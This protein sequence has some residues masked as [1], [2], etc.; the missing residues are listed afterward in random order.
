MVGPE[1]KAEGNQGEVC[2]AQMQH[3][4]LVPRRKTAKP[5]ASPFLALI[6][7]ATD[8]VTRLSIEL[9]ISPLSRSRLTATLPSD[10]DASVDEFQ[11]IV[12]SRPKWPKPN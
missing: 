9:G 3:A 1:P 7:K 2:Q 5:L 10:T 6:N 11:R 12:D 4:L 8:R